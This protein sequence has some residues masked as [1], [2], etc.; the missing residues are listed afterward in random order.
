MEI[1]TAAT[2]S[3]VQ[4][5]TATHSVPAGP[6][7]LYFPARFVPAVTV[8]AAADS[9]QRAVDSADAGRA[10]PMPVR[11]D[12]ETEAEA[13]LTAEIS[14]LFSLQKDGKASAKRSRAELT[15]L[16]LRIAEKLCGLKQMLVGS[17]RDGRWAPYLRSQ[18][19]SPATADRYVAQHQKLLFPPKEKLLS[20]ELHEAT[21]D[22]VR[23]F[24]LKLM[25]KLKAML[26]SRQSVVE[27]VRH[28]VTQI[29]V[30]D[31]RMT[32]DGFEVLGPTVGVNTVTLPQQVKPPTPPPSKALPRRSLNGF[33][34]RT[35]V[36]SPR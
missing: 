17:G 12:A 2:V 21:A 34:S 9:I 18:K 14:T 4:T 22:E 13:N 1:E 33:Y 16:R 15:A 23:E 27:F 32:A 5:S 7:P 26:R 3:S 36:T 35:P 10:A 25:P 19:I 8:V 11:P 30:A 6:T 20:E 28:V 31:G 29:E 24:A